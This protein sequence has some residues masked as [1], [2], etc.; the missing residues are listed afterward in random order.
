MSSEQANQPPVLK[1]RGLKSDSNEHTHL[2]VGAQF[3]PFLQF[4]GRNDTEKDYLPSAVHQKLLGSC[5]WPAQEKSCMKKVMLKANLRQE[6]YFK[7]Y[8]I[9]GRDYN[10]CNTFQKMKTF[11]EELM[12]PLGLLYA[13]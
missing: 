5:S 10:L 2:P 8:M 1:G 13:S 7:R 4:T 12:G 6:K 3:L 11:Q 9:K